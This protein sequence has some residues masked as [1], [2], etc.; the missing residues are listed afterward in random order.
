VAKFLLLGMPLEEVVEATTANAASA[1]GKL[2]EVGTL[3]P[4]SCA[5]IAVFK[6]QHGKFPLIDSYG[7]KRVGEQMLVP[8]HVVRSGDIILG[9]SGS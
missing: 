3:R 4:G 5:D 1:I 6:L 8:T 9:S 2:G 7:E